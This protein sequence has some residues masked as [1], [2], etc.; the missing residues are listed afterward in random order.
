MH[1]TQRILRLI[2]IELSNRANRLPTCTGMTALAPYRDRT[3]RIRNLGTRNWCTRSCT[4]NR[5][6]PRHAHQ[7]R[8]QSDTDGEWPAKSS[9]T[10]RHV[11]N[12]A[13]NGAFTK[14]AVDGPDSHMVVLLVRYSSPPIQF[15]S[16]LEAEKTSLL[17][18]SQPQPHGEKQ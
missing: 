2:M 15:W 1:P 9:Y 13:F 18:G 14:T 7:Q 12:P 3:M 8:Y 11:L 5:L 10:A 16:D 17:L 4:I 6:L